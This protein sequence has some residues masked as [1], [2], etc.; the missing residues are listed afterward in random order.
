MGDDDAGEDDD[1]DDDNE[2][3]DDVDEKDGARVSDFSV[4]FEGGSSMIFS[5]EKV[6]SVLG[7]SL[8]RTGEFR[9]PSFLMKR[10][11]DEREMFASILR[12]P[13]PS[14]NMVEILTVMHFTSIGAVILLFVLFQRCF[15]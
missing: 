6:N 13:P 11:E 9:L 1:D 15:K 12:V 10:E 4:F 3:R 8:L 5:I 14:S 7:L 2:E